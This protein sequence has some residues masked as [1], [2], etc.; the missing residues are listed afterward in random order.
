MSSIPSR[1]AEYLLFIFNLSTF[2]EFTHGPSSL[3]ISTADNIFPLAISADPAASNLR[4]CSVPRVTE[5]S[6]WEL[7]RITRLSCFQRWKSRHCLL[8]KA[9]W[10]NERSRPIQE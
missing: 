10:N 7:N 5:I 6:G 2:P 3:R 1:L 8:C 4:Y 9:L